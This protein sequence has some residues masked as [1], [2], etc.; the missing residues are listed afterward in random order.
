MY[1]NNLLGRGDVCMIVVDG[2]EFYKLEAVVYGGIAILSLYFTIEKD[3]YTWLGCFLAMAC[4]C[5]AVLMGMVLVAPAYV[6][7]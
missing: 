4:V 5:A 2:N 7:Y 1:G 6:F 3:S